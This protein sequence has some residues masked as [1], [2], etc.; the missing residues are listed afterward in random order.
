MIDEKEKQKV[1]ILYKKR[2]GYMTK[3]QFDCVIDFC[4]QEG[5]ANGYDEVLN[6]LLDMNQIVEKL[7]NL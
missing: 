1:W 3:A 6:Y 4:W 7:S 5:H 2:S